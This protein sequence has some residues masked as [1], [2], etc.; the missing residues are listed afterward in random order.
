M[1]IRFQEISNVCDIGQNNA[2][3]FDANINKMTI[4][5]KEHGYKLYLAFDEKNKPC[6]F[7]SYKDGAL[8]HVRYAKD[9]DEEYLFELLKSFSIDHDVTQ[10]MTDSGAKILIALSIGCVGI[11]LYFFGSLDP[12]TNY[13]IVALCLWSMLYM[14]KP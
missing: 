9:V 5:L 7:F 2:L 4:K 10:V 1:N 8:S 6:A 14:L 13:G 11:I 3:C 12:V